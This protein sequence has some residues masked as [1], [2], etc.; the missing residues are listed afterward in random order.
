MWHVLY[1]LMLGSLECIINTIQY[2][3]NMKLLIFVSDYLHS[4]CRVSCGIWYSAQGLDNDNLYKGCKAAPGEMYFIYTER[5]SLHAMPYSSVWIT[6]LQFLYLSVLKYL[7][8]NK[9]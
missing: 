1:P 7:I 4:Y 2:N 5:V 6:L 3:T 8:P 9:N